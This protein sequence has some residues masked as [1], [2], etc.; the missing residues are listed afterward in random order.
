MANQIQTRNES[1]R[2]RDPFAL[3]RSLFG[4]DPFF[5]V[6]ATRPKSSFVPSFEVKETDEGY[7]LKA[8]L[9]GVKDEDLDVSLHGNVL[10][11]S[12][13]RQSEERKEGETYYLYERQYGSFSRSFSLPEEANGEAINAALK[14]GVLTLS[15]GKKAESKPRKISISKETRQ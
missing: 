12:G 8:D 3:A 11:V 4:F 5:G 14:D 1:A 2:A 10:T 15:I 7:V 13:R 9:P 6:E